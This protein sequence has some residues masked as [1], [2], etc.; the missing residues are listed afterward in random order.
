[1]A[2]HPDWAEFTPESPTYDLI[3]FDGG[4]ASEQEVALTRDE[5]L[6]LKRHL[7]A[8]R[9][10][11]A[12]EPMTHIGVITLAR[13]R[14]S[15]EGETGLPEKSPQQIASYLQVARWLYLHCPEAVVSTT[16]GFDDILEEIANP[17]DRA[18]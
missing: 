7:A 12:A 10:Y 2:K 17:E 16:E 8:M 3:M 11:T 9:G 4:G 5:F 1:M 14:A 15:A 13:D 18:A 6:A